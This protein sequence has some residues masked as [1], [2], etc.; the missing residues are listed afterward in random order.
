[1][2]AKSRAWSVFYV[3]D[4][5]D[6]VPDDSIECLSTK[7][8]PCVQCLKCKGGGTTTRVITEKLHGASNTKHY[9]K[10]Q[11]KQASKAQN[12]INQ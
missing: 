5:G 8:V 10:K 4:D 3:H 2:L 6:R 1:M 12:K 11:R 7:S 9:A